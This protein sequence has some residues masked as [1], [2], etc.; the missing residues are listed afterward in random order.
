MTGF[1]ITPFHHQFLRYS[2]TLG[3]SPSPQMFTIPVSSP[4]VASTSFPSLDDCY[5]LLKLNYHLLQETSSIVVLPPKFSS[6][7]LYICSSIICSSS[8]IAITTLCCILSLSSYSFPYPIILKLLEVKN[9]L[10]FVKTNSWWTTI[11]LL[12]I[13]NDEWN[14]T[15]C[16]VK[17]SFS[18]SIVWFFSVYI[19]H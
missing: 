4:V 14:Q 3:T 2:T 8:N 17:M 9:N 18:G 7:Q 12:T 13:L 11:S 15:L 6:G 1:L 16:L 5:Y 19:V 10:L